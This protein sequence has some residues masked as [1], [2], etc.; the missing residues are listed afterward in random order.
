VGERVECLV[1]RKRGMIA[2]SLS[3]FLSLVD[4]RSV[5][6]ALWSKRIA[7][8]L[9]L[10]NWRVYFFSMCGSWILANWLAG[11]RIGMPPQQGGL[12]TYLALLLLLLLLRV[13]VDIMIIRWR[14]DTNGY[15]FNFNCIGHEFS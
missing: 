7:I 13:L 8:L 2:L 1:H 9:L 11:S 3:L 14:L 12:L 15:I 6:A 4:T 5:G 10:S